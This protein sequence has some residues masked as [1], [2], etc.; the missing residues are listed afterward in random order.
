MKMGTPK[1]IATSS[2]IAN[3][4]RKFTNKLIEC[5]SFVFR[6]SD[7]DGFYRQTPSVIGGEEEPGQESTVV[8]FKGHA[9][10]VIDPDGVLFDF[11]KEQLEVIGVDNKE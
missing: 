2:G 3:L 6:L 5:E 9:C 1:H 10:A 7:I 8:Y 4:T 11:L